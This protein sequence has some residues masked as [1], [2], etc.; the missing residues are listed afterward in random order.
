MKKFFASISLSQII[1]EFVSVIF[2]V[3]FALGINSYRESRNQKKEATN[4]K[5]AILNEFKNNQVKID[6]MLVRNK[7]YYDYLDSLVKMDRSEVKSVQFIYNLD[8]LTSAAWHLVQSNSAS[9]QIDQEFLLDA[10]ELY[11]TQDFFINYASGFFQNVGALLKDQNNTSDYDTAM[12]LY[13]HMNVL[14]SSANGLSKG[15]QDFITT[16]NEINENQPH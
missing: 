9:N 6:S 10:A 7:E 15:Y 11:Q 12:S 16:Y 8:L 3:L 5:M 2:A 14:M 13:F 1:I 4:L